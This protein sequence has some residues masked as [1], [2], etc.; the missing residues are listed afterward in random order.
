MKV[1]L[2]VGSAVASCE[3]DHKP[4]EGQALFLKLLDVTVAQMNKWLY[5]PREP[6]GELANIGTWLR[7]DTKNI[8]PWR[9]H[10]GSCDSCPLGDDGEHCIFNKIAD[11]I[12]A[13]REQQ[14]GAA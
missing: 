3:T 4:L 12:D 14:G 8:C 2:R 5:E 1:E 6:D 13:A 9:V 11:R 10:G 7:V